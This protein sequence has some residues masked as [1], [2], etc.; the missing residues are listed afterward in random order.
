MCTSDFLPSYARKIHSM[1]RASS[2]ACPLL[3][4]LL[5]G[6][7]VAHMPAFAGTTSREQPLDLGDITKNSWALSGYAHRL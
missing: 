4:S 1:V 2:E 7:A 5:A 3:L 6:S